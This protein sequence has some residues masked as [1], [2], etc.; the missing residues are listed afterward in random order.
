MEK[1]GVPQIVHLEF[2][3]FNLGTNVPSPAATR[4][5]I[6]S[7]PTTYV[8]GYLDYVA[9]RLRASI[10]QVDS[11]GIPEMLNQPLGSHARRIP[12]E[13]LPAQ[14]HPECRMCITSPSCTM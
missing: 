6:R 1:T 11:F 10:R 9:A 5:V 3:C 12:G 2:V 14:I 13:R 8:V 7:R 4:G